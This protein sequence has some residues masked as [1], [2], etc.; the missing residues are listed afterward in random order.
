[1]QAYRNILVCFPVVSA[2]F[3]RFLAHT[4]PIDRCPSC[5]IAVHPVGSQLVGQGA[6]ILRMSGER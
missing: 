6:V 3:V 2:S 4:P 5:P 1:M